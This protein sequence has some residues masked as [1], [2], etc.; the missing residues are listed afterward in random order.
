MQQEKTNRKPARA[1]RKLTAEEKSQINAVIRKAKGDGKPRTVQQSIP[2]LAMYTDG[3]CRATDKIYSKTMEFEDISYQLAGNDEKTATFENLC[4]MYNYFDSSISAQFSFF[5]LPGNPEDYRKIIEIPPQ[6]DDFDDVRAEYAGI[7]KQNSDKG[8]NGI[9]RRKYLSFSVENDSPKTAKIRLERIE[10]DMYGHFRALGSRANTL[11][12][13]D[14]LK[15]MFDLFHPDGKD[16]FAFDYD[17][18]PA[19]GLSTKDFIAPTSFVFGDSRT[20]RMGGKIGAASFLQILA[21]EL[22]DRLLSDFLELETSLIVNMHIRSIDQTEAVKM[23]KRKITE[24]DGMK[25]NEQKRAVQGGWDMDILPSDLSTYGVEAKSLLHDLQSR[26]ERMFLLTF[27]VI[28]I[29]DTKEQLENDVFAAAGVAQKH[30]CALYRLD[31]QQEAALMSALP[32]GVNLVPIQRG[33]TT[34]S[35]AIFVPFT[36]GELLQSGEALY[37]GRNALSGNMIMADRKQLK[38]PNGLILGTPGCM[39]GDTKIRLADN[40]VISLA[41][42]HQRGKDVEVQC[43]DDLTGKIV[44]STGTDPRISGKVTELAKI[45][46]ENGDVVECTG[47]HL[48]LDRAGNYC[49]AENLKPGDLLSG[50]HIVKAVVMLTLDKPVVVYDLTVKRYLNFILENGLIVHNSGK[51]FSAKREITN[52]FLITTDDILICDPE[53]EVRQEV[54]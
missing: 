52:A 5:N 31:N 42:L 2:Y 21:P 18:L 23:V 35:T 1:T 50:G 29:A 37:Y 24:L 33:L 49:H 19:S 14:R 3:I 13:R 16:K 15:V 17:W 32:L 11:S 43:Y 30:N 39:A 53:A 41:E 45:S 12:G 48:I 51:S 4:D 46:L 28:N 9:I 7:L 47:N 10:T 34:S 26:N 8:A 6:G 27:I 25:I 38:N 54:A 22:N 20:F 36:T 40:S 44:I